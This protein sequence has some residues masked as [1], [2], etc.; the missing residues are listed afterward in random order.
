MKQVIFPINKVVIY[1]AYKSSVHKSI[2]ISS[3][4]FTYMYTSQLPKMREFYTK[5]TL[6]NYLKQDKQP[7]DD[8]SYH[9]LPSTKFDRDYFRRLYPNMKEVDKKSADVIIC[10][11][12]SFY[13]SHYIIFNKFATL[14]ALINHPYRLGYLSRQCILTP[15]GEIHIQTNGG[16]LKYGP[17]DIIIDSNS[18]NRMWLIDGVKEKNKVWHI[19]K[20][21]EAVPYKTSSSTLTMDQAL[22]LFKQIRSTDKL[23]SG[24][25]IDAL[26][27]YN[28]FDLMKSLLV[29]FTRSYNGKNKELYQMFKVQFRSGLSRSVSLDNLEYIYESFG[30]NASPEDKDL[31]FKF[32]NHQ[33]II[34]LILPSTSYLNYEIKI[35]PNNNVGA[36]NNTVISEFT[37]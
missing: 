24:A 34:K 6:S 25:G 17:D 8:I 36:K 28:G 30:Q 11:D 2:D 1:D 29:F 14:E 4:V 21:I 32:I 33:D 3:H 9:F 23:V 35:K 10:D 20:L 22:I 19:N 16:I 26:F 37:L 12:K 5:Y 27:S 13:N 31:F 7:K 18:Y 15:T